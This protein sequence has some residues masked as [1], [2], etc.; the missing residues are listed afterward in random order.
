MWGIPISNLVSKSSTHNYFCKV[1]LSTWDQMLGQ[2]FEIC[3]FLLDL[4][5]FTIPNSSVA[6]K[7][8]NK[9]NK[10][11]FRVLLETMHKPCYVANLYSYARNVSHLKRKN[12]I[13]GFRTN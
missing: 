1:F 8:L 12:N 3:Q 11:L 13:F 4:F 5:K 9:T 6:L 7:E 2:C 10:T